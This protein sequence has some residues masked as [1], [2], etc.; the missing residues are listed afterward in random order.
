MDGKSQQARD[1]LEA[2][3]LLNDTVLEKYEHFLILVKIVV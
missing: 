1:E 3:Y 2:F